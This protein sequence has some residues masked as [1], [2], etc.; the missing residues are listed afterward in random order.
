MPHNNK[1]LTTT[2]VKW[3]GEYVCGKVM[4]FNSQSQRNLWTKLHKKSCEYCKG[5]NMEITP[6]ILK[7]N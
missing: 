5:Q 4:Q 1:V 7:L 6:T 2:F 3:D